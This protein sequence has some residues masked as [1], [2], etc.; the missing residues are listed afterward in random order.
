MANYKKMYAVLCGAVDDAIGELNQ[1][2]FAHGAPYK[3]CKT[4]FIARR[5]FTSIPAYMRWIR[6]K[7]RK[8]LN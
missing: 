5:K 7:S 1:F 6:K 4:H 3:N 2:P 8:L